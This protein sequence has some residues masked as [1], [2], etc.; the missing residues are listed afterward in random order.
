MEVSRL[1]FTS[2]LLTTLLLT[3]LLLKKDISMTN[4]YLVKG[5]GSW[6]F[7]LAL[8]ILSSSSATAQK[9]HMKADLQNMHLWRGM[10]VADGTV[11]TT[12]LSVTDNNEHFHF[13]FWGGTNMNGSYKEFDN[14]VSYTNK[15][16]TLSVWDIYNFSPDAD[17]NNKELF[18]YKAHETGRFIDATVSYKAPESFPLFVSWSTIFYGR[19]RDGQNNQNRYSTFVYADYPIYNKGEWTVKPGIGGAFAFA[20]GKDKDGKSTKTNFYGDTAG[21]VHVS[22]SATYRLNAFKHEFPITVLALWNPQSSEG[23]MQIGVQ[24]MRL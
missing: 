11:I 4:T 20:P 1:L 16:L 24:L 15:G 23:Y 10:E 12:D 13:G 8:L 6:L 18:N 3:S 19:D 22:L 5:K 21:I 9:L 2:I 14:Y 7:V 17:Y